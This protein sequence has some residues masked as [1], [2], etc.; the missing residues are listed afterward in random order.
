M[1]EQSLMQD[2]VRK[3]ESVVRDAGATGATRV[4]VRRGALSHMSPEHLSEHFDRMV[5]G[6]LLTGARLEI[7]DDTDVA[8]RS[9]LDLV[10]TA[11]DVV[12]GE[13]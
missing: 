7:E 10:L 3:A 6:T 9:A 1:H 13:V 5:V 12:N 8:D 2:L 4:M 11:V